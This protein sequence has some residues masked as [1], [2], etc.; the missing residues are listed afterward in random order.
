MN[1]I[2]LLNFL[3]A[4]SGL[5]ADH[6]VNPIGIDNPLPRFSWHLEDDR[7]GA[8]QAAYRLIVSKD[9]LAFDGNLV[10]DSGRVASDAVLAAYCGPELK[11]FTRYWWRV[12]C[13]NNDGMEV[14]SEMAFFE[15]G[16]MEQKNWR[17]CWISDKQG[18]DF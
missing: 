12:I 9:P 4:V 3:L 7:P 11:P 13:E 15:T 2:L 17:G 18:V 8:G 5:M 14:Q 1:V 16:M 6:L 10:W